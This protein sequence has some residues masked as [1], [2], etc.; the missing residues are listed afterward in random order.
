MW[1]FLAV[2]T[3]LGAALP[4]VINGKGFRLFQ[5]FSRR[6]APN[7]G[8]GAV[9]LIKALVLLSLV[10][11]SC[12]VCA[13]EQ[14]WF[15]DTDSV[16]GHKNGTE[17]PFYHVCFSIGCDRPL[18]FFKKILRI[19]TTEASFLSLGC[20]IPLTFFKKILRIFTTEVSFLSLGCHTIT[21]V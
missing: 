6:V 16:D 8:G 2:I 12:C 7:T 17:A 3:E 5:F 13:T 11:S 1:F 18:T 14:P 19:F 10:S 20:H 21:A 9:Q 15:C 4:R